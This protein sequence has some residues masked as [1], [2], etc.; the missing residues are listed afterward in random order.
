MSVC[1]SPRVSRFLSFLCQLHGGANFDR[2][3]WNNGLQPM[4]LLV[5]DDAGASER[6]V[7]PKLLK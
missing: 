6:F 5:E 2:A 4:L 3:I 1:L 7:E